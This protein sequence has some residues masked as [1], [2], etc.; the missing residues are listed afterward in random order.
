M[1]ADEA[2]KT[3]HTHMTKYSWYITAKAGQHKEQPCIIVYIKPGKPMLKFI[4][5]EKPYNWEDIPVRY[6]VQN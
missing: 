2:V 1:T 4:K 3:I 6:E 5:S